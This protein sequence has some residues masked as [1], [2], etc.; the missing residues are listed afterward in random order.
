MN[1]AGAQSSNLKMREQGLW[2]NNSLEDG[3][4]RCNQVFSN[5]VGILGEFLEFPLPDLRV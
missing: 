4:E 3:D 1:Q 5:D 2:S